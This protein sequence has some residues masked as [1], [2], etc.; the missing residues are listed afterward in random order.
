VFPTRLSA[1]AGQI[2]YWGSGYNRSDVAQ[3]AAVFSTIGLLC[4]A[5][6]ENLT[7][8]QWYKNLTKF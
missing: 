7:L 6:E 8:Q 4:G 2:V 3:Q 1:C 5:L